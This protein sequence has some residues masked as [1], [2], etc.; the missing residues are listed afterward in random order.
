MV[1]V[2]PAS[3][4]MVGTVKSFG[5]FHSCMGELNRPPFDRSISEVNTK[6]TI[7]DSEG[8]SITITKTDLDKL[9]VE[10]E[11]EFQFASNDFVFFEDLQSRIV[12]D[13]VM[14]GYNSGYTNKDNVLNRVLSNNI[15]VSTLP[16]DKGIIPI[17][18]VTFSTGSGEIGRASCRERV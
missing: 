12:M 1:F 16:F 2:F 14:L 17:G 4:S 3:T 8:N 5:M 6:G 13:A 18:H 11:W 9:I 10:V 7:K 15:F